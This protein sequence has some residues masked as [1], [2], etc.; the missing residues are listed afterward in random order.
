MRKGRLKRVEAVVERQQG[1]P[2]EGDN[3]RLVSRLSTLERGSFGPIRASVLVW[4]QR[5]FCT[6]EGLMP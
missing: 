5:H 3:D 1:V 4:R 6:V 2:P